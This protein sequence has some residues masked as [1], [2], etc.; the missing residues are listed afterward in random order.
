MA[1]TRERR[2]LAMRARILDAAR[3][4]LQEEGYEAFS[5]RKLGE[6]LD[7]APSAVYR[8]F[9]DKAALLQALVDHDYTAFSAANAPSP[10]ANP[11]ERIRQGALGYVEFGLAHPDQYRLLFMTP[12]R[13]P[14]A[15][16]S[17]RPSVPVGD[18]DV[19]RYASLRKAVAEALEDGRFRRD[20]GDAELITQALWATVHGVVSLH[21]I[22][23]SQ[24][25]LDWRDARETTA[26]LVDAVLRGLAPPSGG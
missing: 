2:R 23:E 11:V 14:G 24:P 20:A 19:D 15:P 8:H 22:R 3:E 5:M 16:L 21:L 12:P 18:P 13:G 25:W 1:N 4:L 9:R 7:Y 17:D 26:T 10:T 6:R